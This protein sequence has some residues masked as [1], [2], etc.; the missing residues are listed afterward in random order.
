VSSHR[1]S[2]LASKALVWLLLR[3]VVT[4]DLPSHTKAS[5]ARLRG[6]RI[7]WQELA[8][9]NGLMCFNANKQTTQRISLRRPKMALAAAY[10]GTI[11]QLG[12]ALITMSHAPHRLHSLGLSRPPQLLQEAHPRASRSQAAHAPGSTATSQARLTSDMGALHVHGRR[13]AAA[14][15]GQAPAGL[16][17]D[18]QVALV[19]GGALADGQPRQHIHHLARRPAATWAAA[20]ASAGAPASRRRTALSRH[21]SAGMQ[22]LPCH[23]AKRAA[24]HHDIPQTRARAAP[25]AH[26]RRNTWPARSC[27][28]EVAPLCAR[29]PASGSLPGWRGARRR[30]CLLACRYRVRSA[31]PWLVGTCTSCISTPALAHSLRASSPRMFLRA[32]SD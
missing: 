22:P 13:R 15:G 3:L 2:S 4:R 27:R 11:R 26:T 19:N 10:E 12:N 20:L 24:G 32:G 31:L 17:A 30:A 28:A 21:A 23:M 7:A 1:S 14:R 5:L 25:L 16:R 6:E 18:V 8:S 9:A 29:L